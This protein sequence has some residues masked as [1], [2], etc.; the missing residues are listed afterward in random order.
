MWG[1]SS[2]GLIQWISNFP[3]S[4]LCKGDLTW[5]PNT[6][7]FPQPEK[8]ECLRSRKSWGTGSVGQC[9]QQTTKCFFMPRSTQLPCYL[10]GYLIFLLKSFLNISGHI[11]RHHARERHTSSSHK[12]LHASPHSSLRSS[13]RQGPAHPGSPTVHPFVLL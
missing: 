5:S 9:Q 3:V 4:K 10:D 1:Q 13:P 6:L 12:N 2:E 11:H 7:H 8:H